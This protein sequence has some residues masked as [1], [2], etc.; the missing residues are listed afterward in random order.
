MDEAEQRKIQLLQGELKEIL[1]EMYIAEE[2]GIILDS[3]RVIPKGGY[4]Y[5]NEL[6]KKANEIYFSIKQLQDNK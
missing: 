5:F 3:G 1:N 4:T 6:E 2:E